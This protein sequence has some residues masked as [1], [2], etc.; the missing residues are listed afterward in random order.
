LA[1]A[2]PARAHA[3]HAECK[4]HGDRVTVEAF[5]AD[6]TPAASA[7][8]SVMAKDG[9]EVAG[10]RTDEKGVWSFP[11]PAAGKYEVTVDAGAGHRT[12]VRMT[13]PTET[14]VATMSPK[15]DELLLTA[16]PTREELSRFPWLRAALGVAAVGGLAV[17]W[18]LAN[19]KPAAAPGPPE[20]RLG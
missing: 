3:L 18:W 9:P 2:A 10:G 6:N 17:L 14:A 5:F 16:G 15:P 7:R 11:K 13:V 1:A 20:R 19:R 12:Q 8:V 4:L